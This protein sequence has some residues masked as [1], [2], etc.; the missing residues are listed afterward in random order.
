MK[1]KNHAKPFE[2]WSREDVEMTFGILRND[3]LDKLQIWLETDYQI[4]NEELTT[5]RNLQKGLRQD[6]DLYNEDELKFFFISQVMNLINFKEFTYRAFTQRRME[7]TTNTADNQEITVGGIVELVVATGRQTPKKPFFFLQEFKQ[8]LRRNN[9]PLGQL[10]IAMLAAQVQNQDGKAIY[11][12]YVLGEKWH[13]VV[14]DA[15]QY[16]ASS[17]FD[18]TKPHEFEQMIRI[19]KEQ[20][21]YI[22]TEL[23]LI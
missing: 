4:P 3:D 15:K 1:T 23:G 2:Q 13:F 18:V 9:D 19:L 12:C 11:G 8:S 17:G 14:L 20:K 10:L 7:F 16:G 21:R 5:I 6:I 22:E